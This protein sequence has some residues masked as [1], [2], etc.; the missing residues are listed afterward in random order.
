MSREDRGLPAIG[1]RFADPQPVRPRP[2]FKGALRGGNPRLRPLI[3][4]EIVGRVERSATRHFR[5][6]R[7]LA[8][9][10]SLHPPYE[11]AIRS[12]CAMKP[13][14]M[15]SSVPVTNEASSEARNNT[16]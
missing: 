13:P 7:R 2:R 14:S 6:R 12:Y 15:T 16:P 4:N 5:L 10:A 11:V 8:G 9:Y 1:H 3:R